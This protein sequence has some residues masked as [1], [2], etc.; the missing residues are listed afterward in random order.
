VR[1]LNTKTD[2]PISKIG[3]GTWQFG[4]PEWNYGAQYASVDAR[5]IVAR[6]LDLGVTLF[7]T[8]EIYGMAAK[9][10]T[11]RGLVRGVAVGD[12]TRA[13]GFGRS[14]R[15]LGEALGERAG[16]AFV[17]TKFYPTVPQ[18]PSIGRRAASSADR[19]GVPAI[20]LFQIHQPRLGVARR[21]VMDAVRVLQHLECIAEVGLSNATVEAWRAADD[22]L[23][24]PVLSNQV[25]YSLV[26]RAAEEEL[27]PFAEANDRVIIAFSPLAQGLLSG[28]YGRGRRPA[29]AARLASPLFSDENLDRATR[30]L[31]TLRAVADAHGATPAQVALAW[32]IR[33]PG[34][35][36]IPGA[37]SVEQLE[38]NVAAADL[39]L[40]DDEDEVLTAASNAFRP[41][42]PTPTLRQRVARI[43][44]EI[45]S[46]P[47]HKDDT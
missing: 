9:S 15:I 30:L 10:W 21:G 8:A 31:D 13:E 37:A 14:E 43:G 1:Y 22:A 36:A 34:V 19:L 29:N 28:R 38:H 20:D 12:P 6:A 25:A 23:G 4:S 46:R 42:I 33:R 41:V 2:K 24:A 39:D 3:L 27:L 40:R 47:G 17:A 44:R 5:A 18:R 45:V 35:A 32:V 7:D 26:D 16:Q 11:C